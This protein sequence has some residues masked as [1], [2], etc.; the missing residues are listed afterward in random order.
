MVSIPDFVGIIGVLAV[1][2]AYFFSQRGILGIASGRYLWMN[3]LGSL[4]IVFSLF[5]TWNLSAF[6]INASWAA[7]SAYGLVKRLRKE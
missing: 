5:W 6:L 3:L 2:L 1:L 7:I 4:A